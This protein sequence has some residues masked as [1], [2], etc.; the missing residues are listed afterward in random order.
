MFPFDFPADQLD[1]PDT[2]G[3]KLEL[4]PAPALDDSAAT[5]QRSKRRAI[6]YAPQARQ[7]LWHTVIRKHGNLVDI[8]KCAVALTVKAGPEIRDKDLCALQESYGLPLPLETM[9]IAKADKVSREEVD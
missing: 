4:V 8:A 6:A 1:T 5:Y 3:S 7:D 9:L 2:T